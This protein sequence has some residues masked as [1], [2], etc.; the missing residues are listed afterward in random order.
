MRPQVWGVNENIQGFAPGGRDGGF[1]LGR[2]TE[3]G[4]GIGRRF[5][6]LVNRVKFLLVIAGE[7]EVVVRDVFVTLFSP[8]YSTTPSRPARNGGAR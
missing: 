4:R 1:R 5:P 8:R 2:R 6:L 7:N 3:I